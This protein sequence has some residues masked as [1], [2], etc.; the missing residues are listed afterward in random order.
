MRATTVK[1]DGR[2]LDDIQRLKARGQ[3]VTAFVRE[4]LEREIRRRRAAKA[5]VQYAEFVREHPDEREWLD[6]WEAADLATPARSKS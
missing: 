5:A 1:V 4:A 3:T 6:E 2:L